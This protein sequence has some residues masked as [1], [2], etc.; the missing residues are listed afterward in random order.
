MIHS[1]LRFSPGHDSTITK[2]TTVCSTRETDQNAA[3]EQEGS[4]SPSPRLTPS[5]ES[6]H[7]T[8]TRVASSRLLVV[9]VHERQLQLAAPIVL[10]EGG[11]GD[12]AAAGPAVDP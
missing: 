6:R 7:R 8:P 3:H 9:L 11:S 5:K 2:F 1:L 12:R 10:Q 4:V